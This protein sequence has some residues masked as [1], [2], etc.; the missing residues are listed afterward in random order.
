MK[1]NIKA[2]DI[3]LTPAIS[4]YLEKK[5]EHLDRFVNQQ[6]LDTVMCYAEIGKSTQHHK[7]GDVFVTELTIHIGGKTFRAK[8]EESDLYASMDIATESMT[9]ELKTFKDRKVSG[10]RRTGAK[11]KSLIKGFYEIKG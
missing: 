11:I 5:I 3:V 4:E 1:H 8:A 10:I 7:N 9:E 2:V 6:V